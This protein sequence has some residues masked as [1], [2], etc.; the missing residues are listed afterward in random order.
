MNIEDAL[1]WLSNN[2]LNPA[3]P[4]GD[5]KIIVGHLGLGRDKDSKRVDRSASYSISYEN[6]F[7]RVAV[8]SPDYV[9]LQTKS[10][11]DATDAVCAFYKLRETTRSDEMTIEEAGA[12]LQREGLIVEALYVE[13]I[14]GNSRKGVLTNE[15][16]L[17]DQFSIRRHI[18]AWLG[19]HI[20]TAAASNPIRYS[21]ALG[22]VVRAVIDHFKGQD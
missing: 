12:L 13:T 20:C 19:V 14:W 18:G 21:R 6:N 7:W 8:V 10:L 9:L 15:G 5:E 4:G 1:E 16:V 11:K 3:Y 17:S 22:D 2:N